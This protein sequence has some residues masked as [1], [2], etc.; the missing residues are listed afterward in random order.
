[1]ELHVCVSVFETPIC[2]S[3]GRKECP[4]GIRGRASRER[5]RSILGFG[6][7]HKGSEGVK[8]VRQPERKDAAGEQDAVTELE[9]LD[10]LDIQV[11]NENAHKA[12]GDVRI[13]AA[14]DCCRT[15]IW[16][17]SL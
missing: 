17:A 11:E 9:G 7:G 3:G 4:N 15:S 5:K 12:S 2:K 13:R 1:M 8:R 10:A 16:R 14:G 6:D